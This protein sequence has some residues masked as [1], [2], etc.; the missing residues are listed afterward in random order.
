MA[1][2]KQGKGDMGV[3][4][5]EEFVELIK[6]EVASKKANR[7]GRDK[8]SGQGCLTR[9]IALGNPAMFPKLHA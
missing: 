3:T 1:I 2:R 6:N 9:K 7:A 4:G 5:I 8:R